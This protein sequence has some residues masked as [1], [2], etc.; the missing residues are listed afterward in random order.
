M[1]HTSL[2]AAREAASGK[3]TG[4]V[5]VGDLNGDGRADLAVTKNSGHATTQNAVI[6]N[7]HSNIKNARDVATGQASGKRMHSDAAKPSD[8]AS[9][10]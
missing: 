7:S 1:P 2:S 9:Q 5:A 10:K 4:R 8:K 3:A 6:N